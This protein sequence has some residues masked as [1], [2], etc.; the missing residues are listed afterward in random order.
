MQIIRVV[1]GEVN[2]IICKGTVGE[3]YNIGGHNEICNIDIVEHIIYELDK[4]EEL[5]LINCS[6]TTIYYI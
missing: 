5:K 2:S 3:V 1:F 4:S 6:C